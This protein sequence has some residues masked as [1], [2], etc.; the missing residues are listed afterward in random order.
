MEKLEFWGAIVGAKTWAF[1]LGLK[2]PLFNN[3]ASEE[4]KAW[5]KAP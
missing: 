2:V 3:N 4:K 5:G 1:A